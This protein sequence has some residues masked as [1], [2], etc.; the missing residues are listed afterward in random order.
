MLSRSGLAARM[1]A[2]P[3]QGRPRPEISHGD[4]VTAMVGLL[5]LGK[6]DF[7]AIET[8]RDAPFF[9]LALGLDQV[10][11]AATLR[12]RLNQLRDLGGRMIREESADLIAR[13]APRLTPCYRVDDGRVGDWVPLDI[14][15]SAFDNS[16]TH[17]EGV[18]RTY[19]KVDG[20]AP[21]LAYLGQEGYL[22]NCELR[23]GKQHS[24]K[25]FPAFLQ[26]TLKLAR[27]H[28]REGADSPR[29]CP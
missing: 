10:P 24:E 19:K 18:S 11:S 6:P 8:F 15:V 22:T 12:Q 16:K 29:Q 23:E 26:Q 9:G 7:E 3:L 20:Y 27:R 17:K 25:G 1:D 13:H 28:G 4:V 21:I 14:D 5:T 2:I